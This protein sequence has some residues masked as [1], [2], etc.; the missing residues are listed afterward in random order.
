MKNALRFIIPFLF[1]LAGAGLLVGW[2]FYIEPN[3]NT[4]KVIVA[5]KDIPFKAKIT[6]N[7]V[8]VKQIQKDN[9]VNGAYTPNDIDLVVGKYSSIEIKQGTQ[10]YSDLIDSFDLIPNEEKGE[11]IAPIPD[12]WLFA[13][14]GSLRRTFVADFYVIPDKERAV[15]ESLLKETKTSNDNP[16]S[17]EGEPES[18]G[19]EPVKT[20]DESDDFVSEIGEPV[21]KNVRVS[22]VKDRANKE[23]KASEESKDAATG[24]I[25]NME[26]VTDGKS[27]T[28]LREYTE[29]GYKLYVVYR[30]ERVKEGE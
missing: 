9:I 17:S 24:V 7:D 19:K 8:V 25:A 6:K 30:Y 29:K 27:L 16:E 10:V 18:S 20:T 28:K 14:P 3:V 2:T 11:F 4:G 12:S 23:V 21:L 13:V 1:L 15:I 5:N 22:S 26:I